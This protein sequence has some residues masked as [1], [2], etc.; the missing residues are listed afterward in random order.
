MAMRLNSVCDLLIQTAVV[1]HLF[2]LDFSTK[3]SGFFTERN[4]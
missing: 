1:M 4:M 2:H 3:M